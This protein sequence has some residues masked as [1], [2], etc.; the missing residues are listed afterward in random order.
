MKQNIKKTKIFFLSTLMLSMYSYLPSAYALEEMSES[1][2]RAID[3]QDGITTAITYSNVKIDQVSWIDQSGNSVG[4]GEQSLK[5]SI[6][7]IDIS[8]GALDASK[9][10]GV[11]ANFDVFTA[12][13][14]PGVG[15]NVNTVLGKITTN[16]IKVCNN[17][18]TCNT[19][20]VANSSIGSLSV[21]AYDPIKFNLVT[22]NGLFSK[23]DPAYLDFSVQNMN[24]GLSQKQTSTVSNT[25]Q[26]KNFNFNFKGF[27]NMYIDPAGGLSLS[28]GT[29]G[30]GGY[31]DFIRTENQRP[32][33]NLEFAINN[34]GLLQA[35]A[36]G[37]LVN[38]IV[39]LGVSDINSSLLGNAGRTGSP[40]N[41]SIVGST[42]VKL[43][44][45]GE[46]TNDLDVKNGLITADKATTLELS[47]GG[48]FGYGF[49]FENITPLVTRTGLTGSETGDVALS[50]ARGGL[51]M[52]GIYLNLVDSNMLKLPEN[53]N[54]TGVSLGGVSKLATLSDFDQI[55]AVT[56]AGATNPNSAVLALRGVNFAALS[57]RGQF[58]A[59]PDVTDASKLPSSTPS[60][61]GL[62]LPIYNLNANVAFYGKQSNGLVDK[63]ITK[64][65]VGS[66]V[67]APTITGITGSE[68]IGFS[69]ALSTQGVSTDGTKST[70]IMLIDGGDNTNYNQAGSIKSTPTDYYI[71]LRNI[72]MLL[73]GYGSIG[74]ENGQLNVSM[75]SL[76]MIIAAQLAAGYLPGAKYKTCPTTGGCYAP[77]NGF[78][79]N[80]DVL[81]GLKIKLNGGIN[82]ALVLRAL[83][84]D[85]SQLVNGTNA[86]NVVGLMNL[87][88]S[89]PLNNVLQLSDPD[90]STIGLDNLS[91]AVGF[92]N[93]IAINKDNVGFNFSFIFNPDKNKDGVFRAR[94]LNL[95]PATTTGG[96]TTVG[97]PQ[98]L[99]EIAITGG[100]LNSSMS[101]I[102][103]D[104]SFNFN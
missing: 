88:S 75:P 28:S 40:T 35:G 21:E 49:R 57:R 65:N 77:S 20:D 8:R 80:N 29:V 34:K 63:I 37:R 89:Q 61:W 91:G 103:R 87:N 98:R 12:N 99:G 92:D 81:A 95:Y 26:M 31:A 45:T 55:I 93:S 19:A 102:P 30:T 2:M 78:T 72:D 14:K 13:G 84:T 71:G 66:D 56:A 3:G 46:F 43:K 33:L 82:F 44:I 48:A 101:I 5:A 85:Q 9:N 32:G 50:T 23:N 86:L 62:G 104:T 25:L 68:R 90:G 94:D 54:L 100:R 4:T 27:G 39:Q 38:G 6:N 18:A 76:K 58:I 47:N 96:V 52:D 7:G 1:D 51:D 74:L 67:Y 69:A 16:S 59:T 79:T 41:N 73:N 10:L 64:N 17:S 97:N 70:S 22:S 24:L 15:L 36:N 83:L 53:K 42:G 60:K 11:Q